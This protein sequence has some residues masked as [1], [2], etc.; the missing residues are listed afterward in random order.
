MFSATAL[1]IAVE[2]FLNSGKFGPDTI[3]LQAKTR[4]LRAVWF[5]YFD[6]HQLSEGEGRN[7]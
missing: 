5:Y 3:L 6:F 4:R 7:K 2:I 1:A